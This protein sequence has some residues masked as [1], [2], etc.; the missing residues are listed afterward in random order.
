MPPVREAS[1]KPTAATVLPA[2]VA[3][4]NQKRRLAPGSSGASSTTSSSSVLGLL[5]VLGLLLVGVEHVVVGVE[6]GHR[7]VAVRTLGR[8]LAV[9]ARVPLAPVGAPRLRRALEL[10]D[11][12]RERPGERVDLVV[13]ELGAVEELRLLD[14]EQSLEPEQQRVVAAPLEA[15]RLEALVE[16][17][18]GRVDGEPTGGSRDE[19]VQRLAREQD[20]FTGELAHPIKVGLGQLA[21]RSRGYV[22]R[23]SHGARKNGSRAAVIRDGCGER[24]KLRRGGRRPSIPSGRTGNPSAVRETNGT[25]V[26]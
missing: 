9:R 10:G 20:R 22:G 3:C 17:D 26:Y 24:S 23:I 21:S 12:R 8:G 13:V 4:S 6:L 1:M 7:A 15:R 2:P 19:G 14:I 18:Q 11:D 5:P 25:G 16:L